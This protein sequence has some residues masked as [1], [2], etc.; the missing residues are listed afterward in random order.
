MQTRLYTYRAVDQFGEILEGT[1][2]ATSAEEVT[3]ILNE[4][5]IQV[6]NVESLT[7]PTH[8]AASNRPLDWNELAQFNEQLCVITKSSLPLAPSLKAIARDL[9]SG[10]LK[11]AMHNVR[12]ELESGASLEEA[13]NRHPGVFPP[14]YGSMVRAGERAG[15]LPAVLEMMSGHSIRMVD[16]KNQLRIILAYPIIVI[17]F[18]VAIVLFLLLKVVPVFA[19]IFQEFG[20]G[21]PAPTQLLVDL[22]HFLFTYQMQLVYAVIVVAALGIGTKL[23][24]YR[25][26]HGQALQD[27]LLLKMPFIGRI[28]NMTSLARFSQSLGLLLKSQVPILESLDLAAA[29]SGNAVLKR[30]VEQATVKVAAGE[31]I[32]DALSDTAYFPH[33]FC[34]FLANGEVNN[35]LPDTLLDVSR[36]YEQNVTISD[37]ALLSMLSPF[38]ISILGL[39]IGFIVVALYL[40]IFTLGDA[41]EG[42]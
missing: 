21:L 38:I 36:S 13:I 16:I 41:M 10:R 20:A 27:R 17:S 35:R 22:S 30:N 8:L 40:P 31:K 14:L 2:E 25:V 32:A 37:K 28:Y 34:W 3:A 26:P 39:T 5:G 23:Y 29:S 7:E 18:S 6:N 42:G 11:H 33:G 4:R 19:E 9:R 24:M 1:M 15:N 12:E